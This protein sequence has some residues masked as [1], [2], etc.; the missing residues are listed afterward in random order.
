M[1]CDACGSKLSAQSQYCSNCGKAVAPGLGLNAPAAQGSARQAYYA[2]GRTPVGDGRVRRNLD[3]VAL[4]WFVSGILRVFAVFWILIVGSVFMPS[5]F[6][7]LR[8]LAKRGRSA[9]Q[10]KN[11][12]DSEQQT[13]DE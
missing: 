10:A 12:Q 3:L 8:G 1:Y 9:T 5:L 2:P 13:S 6:V 7:F 4:M 11:E